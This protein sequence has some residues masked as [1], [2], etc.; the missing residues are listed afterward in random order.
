MDCARFAE[1]PSHTME[2][3][4]KDL[5]A[6]AY[7]LATRTNTQRNLCGLTSGGHLAVIG[8]ARG[9][10]GRCAGVRKWAEE[11]ST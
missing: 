7:A 6:W 1:N 2:G 11:D 8:N 3:K 5:V 4:G 9:V 10:L